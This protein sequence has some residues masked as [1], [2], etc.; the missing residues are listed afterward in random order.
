MAEDHSEKFEPIYALI[1]R[2]SEK[3]PEFRAE[4]LERLGIS[5]FR[6]VKQYLKIDFGVDS[7]FPPSFFNELKL[8]N[9]ELYL[10]IAGYYRRMKRSKYDTLRDGNTF[11][12]YCRNAYMIL[13]AVINYYLNERFEGKF[14]DMVEYFNDNNEPYPPSSKIPLYPI[15]VSSKSLYAIPTAR[16]VTSL[17][18]NFAIQDKYKRY[19][20][21]FCIYDVS[22]IS[23]ER[24]NYL[25]RNL[26]FKSESIYWLITNCGNARNQ[27]SHGS[28]RD[29]LKDNQHYQGF[30]N[31]ENYGEIEK[32][33]FGCCEF[34][35]LDLELRFPYEED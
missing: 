8:D 26:S 29:I 31:G 7:V 15:N 17:F 1:G 10:E 16:K 5:A 25:M 20:S 14:E 12:E 4:L 9:I 19:D 30:L 13:E 18:N 34:L 23:K 24:Y 3:Y 33:I 27:A 35:L 28:K 11:I 32:Y 21:D 2:L 6:E 22:P